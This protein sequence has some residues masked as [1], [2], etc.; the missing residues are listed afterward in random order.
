[1]NPHFLCSSSGKQAI[2]ASGFQDLRSPKMTGKCLP[3]SSL[4]SGPG[5][6]SQIS[7][8]PAAWSWAGCLTLLTLGSV[9]SCIKRE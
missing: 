1:M 2:I 3:V 7:A 9:S 6:S 4:N 5:I 8:P